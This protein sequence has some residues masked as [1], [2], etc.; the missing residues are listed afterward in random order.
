MNLCRCCINYKPLYP[1]IDKMRTSIY[2]ET[3]A[4]KKMLE[5]SVTYHLLL[6]AWTYNK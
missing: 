6:M 5:E 1:N 2:R 3:N 4:A